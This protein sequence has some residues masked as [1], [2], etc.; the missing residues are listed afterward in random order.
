MGK[1]RT[2]NQ[3]LLKETIKIIATHLLLDPKFCGSVEGRRLTELLW[4]LTGE[5]SSKTIGHSDKPR[6]ELVSRILSLPINLDN[7]IT[8]AVDKSGLSRNALIEGALAAILA[9]DRLV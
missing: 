7:A 9:E 4:L 8:V 3:E 2:M 5:N 1:Q 6:V